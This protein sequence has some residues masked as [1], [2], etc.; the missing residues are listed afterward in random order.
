MMERRMTT[1]AKPCATSVAA[2]SGN[3]A[4]LSCVSPKAKTIAVSGA[5]SV[6][7]SVAAMQT[8]GHSAGSPPG[9]T[10]LSTVPSPAPSISNGAST[11][12]EVPEPSATTQIIAFTTRI[13]TAICSTMCWCSKSPMTS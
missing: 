3:K 2:R 12:P 1:V 9:S 11:P 6:A 4:L 13:A 7:P 8:S 5:P 10:W